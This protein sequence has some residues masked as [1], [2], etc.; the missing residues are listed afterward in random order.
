MAFAFFFC[1]QVLLQI[2]LAFE[3]CASETIRPRHSELP[4]GYIDARIRNV[5]YEYLRQQVCNKNSPSFS[6]AANQTCRVLVSL[7]LLLLD[8]GVD[9]TPQRPR[10][11]KMC[12]NSVVGEKN[13]VVQRFRRTSVVQKG[14]NFIL[15][16][17]IRTARGVKFFTIN[18]LWNGPRAP[19]PVR[20]RTLML[21]SPAIFLTLLGQGAARGGGGE[22]GF[23]SC[24]KFCAH[25][26]VCVRVCHNEE[27]VPDKIHNV[28]QHRYF[29]KA[30]A[31]TKRR[32]LQQ[33]QEA[34]LISRLLPFS[35]H[36][37]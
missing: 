7:C 32:K 8:S 18:L 9:P 24:R 17:P 2:W 4:A 31:S 13:E 3:S 15:L 5:H 14:K 27:K 19:P 34:G 11:E 1:Q 23:Q 16:R 25:V 35:F 29:T 33:Q 21:T 37:K 22:V 6:K 20:K 26:C 10:L 28:R 36:K 12:A 30:V